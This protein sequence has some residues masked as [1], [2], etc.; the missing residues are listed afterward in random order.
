MSD[1]TQILSRI[2][3][4]DPNAAEQLLPLV[5]EELRTLAAARLSREN[6]GQTLQATAL[7]H[8]AY[9]RLV[10]GEHAQHW[11]SRGHF[12][13]AAAESMRRIL[14]EAA[15]RKKS[16]KAGGDFQRIVLTNDEPEEDRQTED[17]L[18]LD[19]AL[20]KLEAQSPR[21]AQVVK[22]RYFAGLTIPQTA[23][24]LG[25]AP[26]TVISDWSYARGWL[27]LEISKNL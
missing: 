26:S 4:G 15:R 17:L 21:K 7:V 22:L 27:K 14:I 12:F 16:Q 3:D 25:I 13:A 8:D 24:A 9:L 6:P 18:A 11:N 5:Y 23:E 1:L 2:D 19:E 20:Q 10:G